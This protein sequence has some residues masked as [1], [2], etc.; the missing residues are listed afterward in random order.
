MKY[1][2]LECRSSCEQGESQDKPFEVTVVAADT[3]QELLSGLRARQAKERSTLVLFPASAGKVLCGVNDVFDVGIKLSSKALSERFL[4]R[5]KASVQGQSGAVLFQ[6]GTSF[7]KL[8][9]LV[10]GVTK[11]LANAY[12]RQS[13]GLYVV[14]LDESL[15][16][17]FIQSEEKAKRVEIDPRLAK[18]EE[19]YIGTSLLIRDVRQQLL[20]VARYDNLSVLILGETGTGKSQIAELIHTYSIRQEKTFVDKSCADIP[21][22]LFESEMYGTWKGA[23]ND[24]IDRPGLFEIA[25]KGT[26]FLDEV[27]CI[28]PRHQEKFLQ[29]LRKFEISRLGAGERLPRKVDVRVIFATNANLKA[30]SEAGTFRKD[31]YYRLNEGI[32]IRTPA[33]REHSEDIPLLTTTLW[34]RIWGKLKK[35]IAVPELPEDMLGEMQRYAWSGNVPELQGVLKKVAFLSLEGSAEPSLA[36]FHKVAAAEGM[37]LS[38]RSVVSHTREMVDRVR[39]ELGALSKMFAVDAPDEADE[40]ET[41]AVEAIREAF[42]HVDTFRREQGHKLSD[43]LFRRLREVQGDLEDAIRLLNAGMSEEAGHSLVVQSRIL[44]ETVQW[45]TEEQKV[46]KGSSE[47]T[48]LGSEIVIDIELLALRE[49]LAKNNHD[50]W[51]DMRLAEGWRYGKERNDKKK[52]HQDLVHYDAL[53]EGEKQYDRNMAIGT[54][55]ALHHLGYRIVIDATSKSQA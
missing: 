16:N 23:A 4:D 52:T 14:T 26:L 41:S 36:M 1:E 48:T 54:I 5:K 43:R 11:F 44:A 49:V 51:M 29:V 28:L 7:K 42:R 32:C 19:I 35:D 38:P 3:L 45:L 17:E 46:I 6:D 37:A 24:A 39:D 40:L 47:E 2:A 33:L 55:R 8:A 30:L 34:P 13:P 27:G 15:F 21:S 12:E 31:L 9:S 25:D 20:T 18:L 10:E 50:I 53:P 22:E